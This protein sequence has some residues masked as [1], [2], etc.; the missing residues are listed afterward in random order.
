MDLAA[1][2]DSGKISAFLIHHSLWD[3]IVS[4]SKFLFARKSGVINREWY[5]DGSG[6]STDFMRVLL[7]FFEDKYLRAA[8]LQRNNARLKYTVNMTWP[9]KSSDLNSTEKIWGELSHRL[10]SG[11]R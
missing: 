8:V 11:S 2:D 5:T 9:A 4:K 10:Y 7:S 1:S 3:L 6:L